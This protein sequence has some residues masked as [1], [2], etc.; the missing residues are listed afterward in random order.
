[1]DLLTFSTQLL[2]KG[3]VEIDKKLEPFDDNLGSLKKQLVD[4]EKRYRLELPA[5]PP[6]FDT[7][8]AIWA[9][10]V[11]YRIMQFMIYREFDEKTVVE[12]LQMPFPYDVNA[13]SAYSVDLFFMHLHDIYKFSKGLSES[14]PLV[15]CI[16]QS[17]R[18]WPLS[19]VGMDIPAEGMQTDAIVSSDCL[20]QVYVD[21][22][23]KHKD[24]SRLDRPELIEC[25]KISVGEL[26][27]SYPEI[28]N[29]ELNA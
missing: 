18:N 17:A 12:T 27:E 10:K 22:I 9:L 20:K 2:Q 8:A 3:V 4:F 16:E 7:D 24:Y 19:S 29:L 21:R 23:L 13:S 11:L 1:M 25:A 6:E 26:F 28:K 14:D 5:N 15:K